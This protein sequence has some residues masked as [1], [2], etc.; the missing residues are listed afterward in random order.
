MKTKI[1]LYWIKERQ[2]I[3]ER[4][5]SGKPKP[6]TKDTILQS[7]R[8]CNVQRE[9][10]TTTAWITSNWREPNADHSDLWFAM[11]VARLLNRPTTLAE[12]GLPLPWNPRK[13]VKLIH[14]LKAAGQ[15]AF[16]G[17]Y[18]VST[19][20][21][22]MDKAEYLAERVLAPLWKA[23]EQIRPRTGDTLDEFHT[24][25]MQFDG[26]GSFLAAQVVADVKYVQ[27][28]MHAA[29]W[30]TWAASGPGSRRGLN[31]IC[32]RAVDAPWTEKAWRVA[33]AELHLKIEPAL[34]KMGLRLHAQDLQNALCEVDK[35]YRIM[36]SEGK[37]KCKYNGG[38]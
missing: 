19:N 10:D 33:L 16:S 6:W 7:Y 9:N 26:M 24:R 25:L 12:L 31:R 36:L 34:A 30:W 13:F 15:P 2:L 21:I 37:M 20:G 8:F 27:P 29:D 22:A 35:Y 5:M 11:A 18:V 23:R 28:L 4:R 32:E 17:A 14:D 3:Y 1:L 38:V